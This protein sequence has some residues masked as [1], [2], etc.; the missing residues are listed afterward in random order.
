MTRSDLCTKYNKN[1]T[2]EN[3]E[4]Y[5][6]LS[7]LKKTKTDYFNNIDIKDITDNKRSWTTVNPFFTDKFKICENKI[8]N[9]TDKTLLDAKEITNK[10]N[11]YF[12]DIIKTLNNEERYWNLI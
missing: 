3:W 11:K 4:N 12:K 2:Y 8:L 6:C 10:F 7:I 1:C 5:I 9:E